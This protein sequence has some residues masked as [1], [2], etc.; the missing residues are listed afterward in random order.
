MPIT[1]NNSPAT[2]SGNETSREKQR[3]TLSRQRF[4]ASDVKQR[5]T[6]VRQ[7]NLP[8]ALGV[9]LHT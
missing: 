8:A 3:E 4:G 7:V 5:T 9:M 6:N 1:P 2:I